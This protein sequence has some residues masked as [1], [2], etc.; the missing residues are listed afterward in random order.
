MLGN[1][2]FGAMPLPTPIMAVDCPTAYAP[3]MLNPLML[4]SLFGCV[5]VVGTS[6]PVLGFGLTWDSQ[7]AVAIP[8]GESTEILIIN[9]ADKFLGSM[10]WKR[11]WL[12]SS[13]VSS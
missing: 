3:L 1:S 10:P 8:I 6:P 4:W 12:S 9:S 11:Q 13:V 7:F 5:M 2:R